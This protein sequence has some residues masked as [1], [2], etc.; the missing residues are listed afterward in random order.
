[1]GG[2][3]KASCLGFEVPGS[4]CL[5]QRNLAALLLCVGLDAPAQLIRRL[6]SASENGS[7]HHHLGWVIVSLEDCSLIYGA[8]VC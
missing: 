3:S 8:G 7:E 6:G 2:K 1:M 4:K 5:V